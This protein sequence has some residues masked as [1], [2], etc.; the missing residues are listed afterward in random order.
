MRQLLDALLEAGISL[1]EVSRPL[2]PTR[3]TWCAAVAHEVGFFDQSHLTRHFKRLLGVTPAAYAR[4]GRS[5]AIA[6]GNA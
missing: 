5:F 3:R 6:S 4:H 2:G 1:G